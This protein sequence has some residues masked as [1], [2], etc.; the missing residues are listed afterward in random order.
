[1]TV[2]TGTEH[3]RRLWNRERLGGG[4]TALTAYSQLEARDDLLNVRYYIRPAS[5]PDPGPVF[6]D[7]QLEGVRKCERL[8]ARLDCSSGL[9]WNHLTMPFPPPR[10]PGI[11]LHQIAVMETALP[12]SLWLLSGAETNESVRFRS[13]EAGS[14]GDRCRTPPGAGLLVLSEMYYPGWVATVN[15][16]ASK[17]YPG[18]RRAPRDCRFRRPERSSW[19]TRPPVSGRGGAE[20]C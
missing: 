15:G 7:A 3:G 1:M 8:P 19:N 12:L 18:R 20:P 11:D 17:I 13:Y 5:T 2:A 16:K 6:H 14:D 4:A 9:P 10:P